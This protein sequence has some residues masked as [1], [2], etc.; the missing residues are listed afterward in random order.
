MSFDTLHRDDLYDLLQLRAAVFVVEQNCAYQD[1]DG[2]DRQTWHCLYRRGDRLLAYQRALPPGAS[3]AEDSAL[4]RIVVDPSAR[5][6]GLSRELV[7]RGVEFNLRTWPDH[8]LQ[9]GAQAHLQALY[10]SVGFRVCSEL[11]LE[12][13]IPH[14]HMRYA[15]NES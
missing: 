1:I 7:R 6:E 13:G 4:G 9:I 3:Y 15:G 5:G 14:L 2:L 8:S 10:E 12:D 11:Y